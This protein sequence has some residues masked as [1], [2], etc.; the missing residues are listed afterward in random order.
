[1]EFELPSAASWSVGVKLLPT[2]RTRRFCRS[3]SVTTLPSGPGLALVS[4][5]STRS[6]GRIRLLNARRLAVLMLMAR[7]PR[8][9]R[10]ENEPRSRDVVPRSV[11]SSV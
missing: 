2:A 8:G 3:G 6:P 4:R 10:L 5:T 1:M 11:H 7:I 9:I